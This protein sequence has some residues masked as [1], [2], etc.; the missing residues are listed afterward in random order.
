M[1]IN[2]SNIDGLAL[3]GASSFVTESHSLSIR[4]RLPNLDDSDDEV[5][6]MTSSN[7][8]APMLLWNVYDDQRA[9]FPAESSSAI[10][11]WP[12]YNENADN[13]AAIE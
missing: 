9:F 7:N 3:E 12:V 13:N 10:I 11:R 8:Q 4:F 1:R 5:L 6:Y 2:L